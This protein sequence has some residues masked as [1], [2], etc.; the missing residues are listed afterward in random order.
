VSFTTAFLHAFPLRS[1]HGW[2]AIQEI[3]AMFHVRTGLLT[4]CTAILLASPS[5]AAQ[6]GPFKES[7]LSK[8]GTPLSVSAQFTTQTVGSNFFLTLVLSSTNAAPTVGKADV[9]TS[10]YF[11]LADPVT[12]DRPILTL[13]SA[14]GQAY[15]VQ[16]PSNGGDKPFVWSPVSQQWTAGTGL[17]DLIAAKDF[18]E[19]WRFKTFSPPPVYPGLGFGVGTVGNSAINAFIPGDEPPGTDFSFNPK[20]VSGKNN[21]KPPK[22]DGESM[23]NL[24]I[25]SA[26]S[27]GNSTPDG[28][29]AG[30]YLVRN[31]AVFTF[32]SD[33]DLDNIDGEWI[34][35]NVTFGFGTGPDTVFLPEPGTLPMLAT[36]GVFA[37]GWLTRRTARR[38]TGGGMCPNAA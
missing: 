14:T 22:L 1:R 32:L 2:R 27:G 23:I 38:S 9:L 8:I 5:T 24:G 28:G 6:L 10:F 20:W 34:Q 25:S 17:S 29:L 11:N 19:G 35:G 4:V 37:I 21:K 16:K 15:E 3:A 31:Q 12:G 7:G 18:D 26:G 13:Q 33:R 36:G 30:H